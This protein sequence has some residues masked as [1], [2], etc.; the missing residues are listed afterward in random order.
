MH[1]ALERYPLGFTTLEGNH[2]WKAFWRITRKKVISLLAN[3]KYTEIPK[4]GAQ[5]YFSYGV[6]FPSWQSASDEQLRVFPSLATLLLIFHPFL[7]STLGSSGSS[8][9]FPTLFWKGS[10]AS[11]QTGWSPPQMQLYILQSLQSEMIIRKTFHLL[12]LI[13]PYN[14]SSNAIRLKQTKTEVLL[15]WGGQGL[16]RVRGIENSG[17][18]HW[19]AL[20]N[21]V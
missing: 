2:I 10:N 20:K 5:D 19:T 18:P 6:I 13:V 4:D 11:F 15:G 7:A 12:T 17:L 8:L 1:L 3:L 16:N 9:S 14:K 21:P